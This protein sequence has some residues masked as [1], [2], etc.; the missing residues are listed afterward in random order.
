[1][2]PLHK[3]VGFLTTKTII[4]A[5][6]KMLVK[7]T[8][9]LF[10][11]FALAAIVAA[12]PTG[13]AVLTQNKAL[14]DSFFEN[15][16]LKQVYVDQINE[17]LKAAPPELLNLFGNNKIN[18]Y[19]TLDD[20]SVLSYYVKTENGKISEVLQGTKDDADLEIRVSEGTIEKI[21]QSKDPI[22]SS[23]KALT[24][25]EIKY[26]GLTPEGETKGM[27]VNVVTTVAGIFK[28]IVEFFSSLFSFFK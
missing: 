2:T 11:L 27:V 18:A 24:S 25:G 19:I 9:V 22:D 4:L 20:G 23:L 12:E 3:R 6:K 14:A 28:G 8:L 26:R 7:N 13:L 1:M 16:K 15:G 17:Q 10:T 21:A 5:G